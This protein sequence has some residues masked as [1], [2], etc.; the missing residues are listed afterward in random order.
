MRP[1]VDMIFTVQEVRQNNDGMTYVRGY[2]INGRSSDN[3]P[4]FATVN[5][6]IPTSYDYMIDAALSLDRGHRVFVS[7]Q[8]TISHYVGQGDRAIRPVYKI[9]FPTAF[10]PLNAPIAE[11][12]VQV[13]SEPEEPEVE[14]VEEEASLQ[15]ASR[16]RTV[17]MTGVARVAARAG[18]GHDQVAIGR[19]RRVS[20]PVTAA[21]T[22]EETEYD[23]FG[24]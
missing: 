10:V 7:G 23:P 21:A 5:V 16:G 22:E 3:Q 12:D 14:P 2:V 19:P 9:N 20:P 15:M 6:F 13:G 18:A 24:G 8:C 1:R 17:P 4:Q 11:S